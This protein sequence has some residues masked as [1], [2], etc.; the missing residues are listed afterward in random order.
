MS[1]NWIPKKMRQSSGK[2]MIEHEILSC[3]KMKNITILPLFVRV[4]SFLLGLVFP[5]EKLGG[6]A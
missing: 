4:F 1:Q 2:G 5:L 3:Q 6:L